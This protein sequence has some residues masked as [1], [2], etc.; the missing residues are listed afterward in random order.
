MSQN[1]AIFMDPGY[2]V[3]IVILNGHEPQCGHEIHGEP[4]ARCSSGQPQCSAHWQ[5][6][7]EHYPRFQ[8][9]GLSQAP[10]GV[11]DRRMNMSDE[12]IESPLHATLSSH[13]WGLSVAPAKNTGYNPP[14]FNVPWTRTKL[15][16]RA[17]FEPTPSSASG[18]TVMDHPLN[19]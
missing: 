11:G 17:W 1:H 5:R 2:I 8:C 9:I 3:V 6:L 13:V 16:S 12:K 4:S 18:C 15:S 10:S 14:P 19:H 7:R